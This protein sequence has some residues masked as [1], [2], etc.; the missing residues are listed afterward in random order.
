MPTWDFDNLKELGEVH[1]PLLPGVVGHLR[2][3][4]IHRLLWSHIWG[5][6]RFEIEQELL[7]WFADVRAI[8]SILGLDWPEREQRWPSESIWSLT[9]R[10]AESCWCSPEQL[11]LHSFV[12]FPC[13]AEYTNA[14]QQAALSH[15]PIGSVGKSELC[16]SL[17]WLLYFQFSLSFNVI[18]PFHSGILPSWGHG[19]SVCRW[20]RCWPYPLNSRAR[21]WRS[22][23]G[24]RVAKER[25]AP[26][27]PFS[28]LP[29][30][31]GRLRPS[32]VLGR[33]Q[34][35]TPLEKQVNKCCNC[36][37]LEYL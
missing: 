21:E 14:W 3:H 16:K 2:L 35:P 10:P 13:C 28:S 25:A 12:C 8:D 9:W 32:S 7:L 4:C 37:T 31:T 11:V 17:T 15:P 24:R 30:H 22:P 1:W 33:S 18:S 20:G 26:D 6:G 19:W 27:L 23:C 34:E 29:A 36:I 5:L